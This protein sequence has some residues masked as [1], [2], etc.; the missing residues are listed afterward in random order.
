MKPA[1]V[2]RLAMFHHLTFDEARKRHHIG[3]LSTRDFRL[4]CFL[5][6]WT[7]PRFGGVDAVAQDRYCEQYGY[8]ALFRRYNFFRRLVGLEAYTAT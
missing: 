6:R 5:W 8:P 3:G 2:K 1:N 4:Y 7:T